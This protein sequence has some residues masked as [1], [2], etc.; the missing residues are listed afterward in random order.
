MI[1]T[2]ILRTILVGALILGV[3]AC[4]SNSDST[5]IPMGEAPEAGAS[6]EGGAAGDAGEAGANGEAGAGGESGDNTNACMMIDFNLDSAE[7]VV[8]PGATQS[9][10][11]ALQVGTADE[12]SFLSIESWSNFDG[13][14]G[15]GTFNLEGINYADCGL[16]VL[17]Y[18][19]YTDDGRRAEWCAE[20]VLFSGLW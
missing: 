1:F 13:P 15:P 8:N 7:V 14:T 5:D 6:G 19:D 4:S 20:C 12:T 3:H 16:C 9:P 17:V 11:W 18:A 2:R 10:I